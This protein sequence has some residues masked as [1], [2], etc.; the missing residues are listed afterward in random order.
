MSGQPVQVDTVV[1]GGGQCGLAVGYFLQQRHVSFVILDDNERVGDGWRRRYDSLR[2]YTPARLDGLP[3]M[4][5]PAP[6]NVFPTGQQM[7]DYI[8]AYAQRFGLPVHHGER[9]GSVTRT[10]DGRFTVTTGG[11]RYV[12]ANVVVATGSQQTPRVPS[13]AAHLDPSIRQFHS[14]DY[15]NSS[16][17]QDGSVLV[18]GASHSGADIAMECASG[19]STVLAGSFRGELPFDLEGKSARRLLPLLWFLASHVMTRRTPLG[20]KMKPEL[21]SHGGPLLRFRASD[22]AAA[23]VHHVDQRVEAVEGGKPVLADGTILNP[24]LVSWCTGFGGD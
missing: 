1:V 3:G 13:W 8:E 16:Q 19:H 6:A 12:C 14:A 22:L 2:L 23:G 20:R 4:S 7:G 24:A 10:G 17:L 9:V 21:R 5:F 18:V 15:L 11:C